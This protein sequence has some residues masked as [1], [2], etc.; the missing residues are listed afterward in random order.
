M[1]D[2]LEAFSS[3]QDSRPRGDC[4]D[5]LRPSRWALIS[6]KR[7]KSLYLTA[8]FHIE[9]SLGH[10][11]PRLTVSQVVVSTI[12]TSVSI[13]NIIHWLIFVYFLIPYNL[14]TLLAGVVFKNASDYLFPKLRQKENRN[15]H[16]YLKYFFVFVNSFYVINKTYLKQMISNLLFLN[17]FF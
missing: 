13:Y 4:R 16:G 3:C 10:D 5:L 15:V 12:E 17:P 14:E 7:L 11:M 9:K 2:P 8:E 1:I 6:W